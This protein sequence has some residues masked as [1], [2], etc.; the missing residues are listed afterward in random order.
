[1]AAVVLYALCGSSPVYAQTGSITITQQVDGYDDGQAFDFVVSTPADATT[2]P[3]FVT[4]WGGSGDVNG[5]FNYPRNVAVDQS[6]DVY[7][8]DG[9]N[10]RVQKFSADGPYLGHWGSEGTGDG[11]F[12]YMRD[13]AVSADGYVY[14]AD[15]NR[16]QKFDSDGLY[17]SQWGSAGTGNGE[18]NEPRGIAIDANGDIFV[19]DTYNHRIQKFDSNGTYLTEW[20]APESGIGHFEYP[21]DLVIDSAGNVYVSAES[22]PDRFLIQKF[23]SNGTHLTGWGKYYGEGGLFGDGGLQLAVDSSGNLYVADAAHMQIFKFDDLGNLLTQW[24][25]R[26]SGDG[27]ISEPHGIAIDS[28]NNL[29]VSTSD[30]FFENP[31]QPRNDHIVKY[32]PI[33]IDTPVSGLASGQSQTLTGLNTAQ[34]RITQIAQDDMPLDGVACDGNV[35]SELIENGIAIELNGESVTCT[36]TNHYIFAGT[37]IRLD[38]IL[39]PA[40]PPSSRYRITNLGEQSANVTQRLYDTDRAFQYD[41]ATWE[42]SVGQSVV[43]DLADFSP[44]QFFFLQGEFTGYTEIT[45]DQ[46]VLLTHLP[47][48]YFE[49]APSAGTEDLEKAFTSS[50]LGD[51]IE[52][53]WDFGDGTTST[54]LNPTHL[55]ADEGQYTIKLTATAANGET[56]V[57]TK[58]E[59]VRSRDVQVGT[60]IR[61]DSIQ[62]RVDGPSSRYQI[63]N[64]STTSN[65]IEQVFY[66]NDGSDNMAMQDIG[67]E[68][69]LIVDLA[70]NSP[71]T[72]YPYVGTDFDGYVEIISLDDVLVR[73]LPSAFFVATLDTAS[74]SLG[75]TFTLQTLGDV[76][77]WQ[78]DFGDGNSSTD[79]EPVHT[80]PATGAYTTTLTVA[81]ADDNRHSYSK[82]VY[83][84]EDGS[85]VGQSIQIENIQKQKN[86]PSS[87]YNITNLG[88]NTI[89]IEQVFYE[90]DGTRLDPGV[91]GLDNVEILVL[92]GGQTLLVNLADSSSALEEEFLDELN[93]YVEII[94]PEDVMVTLLPSATFN[95]SPLNGAEPLEVTFTSSPL[96]N[97]T[98]WLWDF[99]DG[100]ISTEITPTHT[101]TMAGKH[102]VTL[103]VSSS[104]DESYSI[105]RPEYIDV[106]DTSTVNTQ[107]SGLITDSTQWTVEGSPYLVTGPLLIDTDATLTVDAG[108]EI[109]FMAEQ[110]MDVAGALVAIGTEE[111]P[112]LFTSANPNPAAGAWGNIRF[113]ESSQGTLYDEAGD[114]YEGSIL[115]YVEVA[116]AGIRASVQPEFTY[117]VDAP[118][119]T[120]LVDNSY[121]HDIDGGSIRVG[122]NQ[123]RIT[124]SQFMS[125]TFRTSLGIASIIDSVIAVTGSGNDTTL[126]HNELT[127][128]NVTDD[129]EQFSTDFAAIY[130]EG[131]RR[132]LIEENQINNI[133]IDDN[134]HVDVYA[135]RCEAGEA[136]IQNNQIQDN[137]GGG[138]YCYGED[139]SITNNLLVNNLANGIVA[140][141]GEIAENEVTGSKIGIDYYGGGSSD[142]VHHNILSVNGTGLALVNSDGQFYQNKIYSN[143]VGI[144]ILYNYGQSNFTLNSIYGNTEYNLRNNGSIDDGARVNATQNWWGTTDLTEITASIY[145]WNDNAQKG[146]VNF[147]PILSDVPD[148][149]AAPATPSPEPTPTPSPEPTLSPEPTPTP[150]PE[151][152]PSAEAQP[153]V[154]IYAV[155]DNNLGESW[156]RLV[157]NI[158][159]G[160]AEGMNVRLLV[161]GPSDEGDVYIY[162]MEQDNDPY[163]PSLLNPTCNGRYIEG[164][165]FW[166]FST[167][168]TANPTSLYQF[169]TDAHNAYPNATQ[170]IVSL[171]G[172]GS[173]WSAN[174][175]P[176]QPRTWKD[177]ND[178]LGGMLWDDHP[179][180]GEANSNSLSTL[181]LGSALEWAT[182]ASGKRIDLLYLDGCSMGMAEVAYDCSRHQTSTGHRSTT[183]TCCQKLSR[184][185][186]HVRW[187]NAGSN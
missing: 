47:S 16:I 30:F 129:G 31:D 166:I 122:G 92:N 13:L 84:T 103:T 156:T 155:L 143:T 83:I 88:S 66:R 73:T 43:F 19:T 65:N 164:E 157:N 100:N 128:I 109:R 56:H 136:T 98:D 29:Y 37:S 38:N 71:D 3:T 145:D 121:F 131:V 63:T 116:Y 97:V 54:E 62:M 40:N 81:D 51:V 22:I 148:V 101:Y 150:S 151:P 165:N 58:S 171:V 107:I 11:Q 77:G 10:H 117:A 75:V 46:D 134:I 174:V 179:Q 124:H 87:R 4:K 1:M 182:A 26:G 44:E 175:L 96:G 172:H 104:P 185:P 53:L 34:Y 42:L 18:F 27:H 106:T 186:M 89:T 95:A 177:Q 59:H 168:D 24:G 78:W 14:V 86:G 183:T 110:S 159:A 64:L 180:A 154:L 25:E 69:S 94:S 162:D 45:S 33:M 139:V 82:L 36:F 74:E 140:D 158:E 126:S 153:L 130:S 49:I 23:D 118:S 120:L 28:A 115:R 91:L 41:P 144:D 146:I 50:T 169:L 147:E 48:A 93:G 55:Y 141:S 9:D 133:T 111:Q 161:D 187:V 35:S 152:T 127:E 15:G 132:I 72:S 184:N 160:S 138:I 5:Q 68:Q 112:I 70:E 7:V 173:G 6:G 20:N 8:I 32:A 57:V 181:A 60:S 176:G 39:R 114:Y 167:E 178:T 105:S 99:G 2:P 21:T 135:I 79:P 61:L 137:V 67:G 17:I 125:S 149:N 52:W 123:S 85:Y 90:N 119:I 102:T 142:H 80:Y 163:C 170:T 12:Q 76:V 113:L 108:V